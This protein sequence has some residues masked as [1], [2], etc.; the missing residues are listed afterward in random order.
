MVSLRIYILVM[1]WEHTF[2]GLSC[3]Y[4]YTEKNPPVICLHLLMQILKDTEALDKVILLLGMKRGIA[5]ISLML[6]V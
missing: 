3:H 1:D 4:Y 6:Q 2:S 5:S